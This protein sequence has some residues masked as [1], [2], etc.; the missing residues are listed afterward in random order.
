MFALTLK[1]CTLLSPHRCFRCSANCTT[2]DDVQRRMCTDSVGKVHE[3]LEGVDEDEK[4]RQ[5]IYEIE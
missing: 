1:K 4:I 2:D 5:I 3:D